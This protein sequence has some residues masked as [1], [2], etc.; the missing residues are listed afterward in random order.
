MKII[1]ITLEKDKFKKIKETIQNKFAEL[2]YREEDTDYVL[3]ALQQITQEMGRKKYAKDDHKD[4]EH[5]AGEE[6]TIDEMLEGL[7]S[8]IGGKR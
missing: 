3:A 2:D 6:H 5:C 4:C 1:P 7:M 8:L